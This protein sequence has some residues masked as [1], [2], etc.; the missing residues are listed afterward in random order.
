M[1]RSLVVMSGIV[2][3]AVLAGFAGAQDI[4]G[5]RGASHAAPENTLAAFDLAWEEEADAIEGDFYYTR[6]QQIVC[7]HDKDT[8]RTAGVKKLVAE[9]TLAELRNL[10]YGG[11]FD[12]RFEGEPIPTFAEVLRSI[13]ADKKFV[14]ELKTGPRIVPLLA[15]ELERLDADPD[16]LLII[17][18]QEATV[19]ACKEQIPQVKAHWLTGYRRDA[20]T[21]KVTPTVDQV[22]KTLRRCGADGLGTNGDRSVV[23]EAFIARLREKGLREF[24]VWTI[25]DPGDARYFQQLGAMAITTNRPAAIRDALRLPAGS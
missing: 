19:A 25:D 12:V 14:V 15:A 4:V 13:P 10:E 21:G 9:S 17:S 2:S 22:A 7:I 6:D 3:G 23:T 16:R 5:H 8:E 11:W 18:F 20:Q 24:H 1:F